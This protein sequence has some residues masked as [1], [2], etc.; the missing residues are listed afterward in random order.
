MLNLITASYLIA[1][2]E[3]KAGRRMYILKI[4]KN[5]QKSRTKVK[6]NKHKHYYTIPCYI[7][8]LVRTYY[9]TLGKTFN[10]L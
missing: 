9:T 10:L 2:V 7:S 5:Q 6:V 4:L 8:N 3:G 1:V